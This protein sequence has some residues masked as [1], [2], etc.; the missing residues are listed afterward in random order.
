MAALLEKL[1]TGASGEMQILISS[2][3][4]K[5]SF[6]EDRFLQQRLPVVSLACIF[7]VSQPMLYQRLREMGLLEN[8]P[9]Q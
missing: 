3:F 9:E 6:G 5:A 4:P 8:E 1:D 7:E 2:M